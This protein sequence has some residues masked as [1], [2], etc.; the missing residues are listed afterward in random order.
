MIKVT[1]VILCGGPGTRLWPLSRAGFPKQF[2]SLT[3]NESLFQQAAQQL[4]GLG[5]DDIQVS[6]PLIVTGEEHRFLASEVNYY[7]HDSILVIK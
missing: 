7:G 3:G 1:P 5:A 4:V 6:K 2:L